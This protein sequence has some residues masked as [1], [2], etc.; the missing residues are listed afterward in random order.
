MK[1]IYL[2]FQVSQTSIS[3]GLFHLLLIV[4]VFSGCSK[5][6]Q[7]LYLDT[8]VPTPQRVDDL[9]ARMSLS[10]KIG[11]LVNDAPAL[12]RLGIPA[13]NWWN[14]SLHGVARAGIAT[15][16]PQSIG[17][18]ATWDP[19]LVFDMATIISDEA[20]AKHHE[21]ERNEQRGIYQ[22]L[23]MWSPNVNIFRDPRWGRGQETYGEDPY[24]TSRIGVAFVKGLQGDDP[25][26]LKVVATPKHYAVHSGPEPER[27]RFNARV[28]H[29]D[30]WETYLPAFEATIKEGKAYSIMGAY[31]RVND[32]PACAHEYL[33]EEVLRELWSFEGY[34]V[35]DCGAIY[36][37]L[38]HHKF[39]STGEEAAALALDKGLDL[40]CGS[41]YSEYLP[42]AVEKGL[43][44]EPEID[45]AVKRLFL[46]RFRLGM[47]DPAEKVRYAQIP[48]EVNDS[49]NHRQHSRLV[50]QK[51]L[52]LLKNENNLLPLDKNIRAITVVGP[53]ADNDETPLGNYHGT[54][55]K[56]VT[57]LE[58]IRNKVS[59]NTEVY[60]STGSGHVDKHYETVPK[61][62]L[63]TPEGDKNGLKAQFFNNMELEGEVAHERID[64][65]INFTWLDHEPYAGGKR[66]T[67]SIRWTGKLRVPETGEYELGVEGDDGYRMFL[68]GEKIIESWKSQPL[69]AT[70][71]TLFL[72]KEKEYPVTIE[73]FEQ[74]FG[75]GIRLFWALPNDNELQKV[76]DYAQKSEVVVMVGGISPRLEGEELPLAIE[77]FHRGDRTE[78]GLPK[79][80][81]DLLKQLKA[82]GKPVILVLMNGSALAVN[83]AHDNIPAIL[84]AWYPGQEGGNAV[85]DVLFG[86]YNPAGRL[87]VTFYRSVEDL[88]PFEEYSME[89]RTYR[90][91]TGEPLYPF[92][93]GLSYSTFQ[94]KDLEL[95]KSDIDAQ[96]ELTVSVKVTNTSS[97]AG[98]EVVQL[99][100]KDKEASTPRPIKEL[101]GFKR[102]HLAAGE[103]KTIRFI[104]KAAQLLMIND[105][106]Q[107]VVEEGEFDIYVGS[108][109]AE[110]H[111]QDTFTFKNN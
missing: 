39:V 104:L 105:Q 32:D 107:R 71:T 77:G 40:D 57:A 44:T 96:T 54:P 111:L 100:V 11:Q 30:L 109:S 110:V 55:S 24:L 74:W 2:P 81:A 12:P 90:Y 33:L 4:L 52:V 83:W 48:Y 97:I 13:Y 53:N 101:K 64:D 16:Y 72:E 106:E 18:G 94:Y 99:Y 1:N 66:D 21:F 103:T 79:V 31:N 41:M 56:I 49:E 14:E 37:I 80:Q 73:Y 17:L 84:E 3:F 60:F 5:P 89:N 88:P 46:A 38:E 6:S 93:Y 85:A 47:F 15:V 35:S 68:D 78:L 8:T 28:A 82:S 108:S 86:D 65:K 27:H 36:D 95:S 23:T 62:F 25:N 20:R 22:G 26:Y 50:A 87:P 7:P 42:A 92:G 59:K 70:T 91:F 102:I 10:E 45:R 69:T 29:R 98:E 61:E 19:D 43:I 51:S 67:F 34:I 76:L 75:A 58:G 9:V 63:F